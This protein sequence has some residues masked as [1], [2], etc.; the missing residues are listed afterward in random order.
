MLWFVLLI[1]TGTHCVSDQGE[2]RLPPQE[3]NHSCHL[4]VS[5]QIP[6]LVY[7]DGPFQTLITSH[8]YRLQPPYLIFLLA[9]LGL[10]M[11]VKK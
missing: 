10:H 8:L 4:S 3:L 5:T 6:F 1:T 9:L 11:S 2:F 7:E